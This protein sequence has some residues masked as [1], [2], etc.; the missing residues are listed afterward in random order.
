M[1]GEIIGE[2]GSNVQVLALFFRKLNCIPAEF[3]CKC[4]QEMVE[5]RIMSFNENRKSFPMNRLISLETLKRVEGTDCMFGF[6]VIQID[7][8]GN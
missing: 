1:I 7:C 5:F 4:H 6:Q 2:H 8:S 3:I